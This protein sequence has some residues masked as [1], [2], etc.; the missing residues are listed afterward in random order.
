[1]ASKKRNTILASQAGPGKSAFCVSV[2]QKLMHLPTW[3]E[4]LDCALAYQA[5][6]D[7][8]RPHGEQPLTYCSLCPSENAGPPAEPSAFPRK[9]V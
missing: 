1:M 9:V 6:T 4:V 2:N 8:V 7:V 5:R 3:E